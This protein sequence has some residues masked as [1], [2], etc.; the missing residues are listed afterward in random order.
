MT[1]PLQ[2]IFYIA[3]YYEEKAFITG[4]K[5]KLKEQ[6]STGYGFYIAFSFLP[7]WW[8]FCQCLKKFHE[9]EQKV[10]LINAAKYFSSMLPPA[11]AI[12][13]LNSGD[14]PGVKYETNTMFWLYFAANFVKSTYSYIWDIYMDWGLLR[15][16]VPG[17]SN[18]FLRDKLNY[19][20]CFYYWAMFS[21]FILR[22]LFLLFLFNLGQP[23]SF[24]NSIDTMF[25]ISTFSEGFRRA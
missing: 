4:D 7:Y 1:A 22:Y 15:R 25:A 2:H 21:D 16:N 12:A 14:F 10:H 19:A 13:L 23:D 18:R 17:S 11:F 20:P 9:T 24:F 8:R 6:C 3:C 5:I